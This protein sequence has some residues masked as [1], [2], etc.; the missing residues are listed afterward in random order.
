MYLTLF[1]VCSIQFQQPKPTRQIRHVFS[2][3][4]Q[5]AYTAY[6]STPDTTNTRHNVDQ[7]GATSQ[8]D[9]RS[10]AGK[11]SD[12]SAK[13][14]A[15]RQGQ[16]RR[17]L[18]SQSQSPSSV[19]S[20]KVVIDQHGWSRQD[21][22]HSSDIP[23]DGTAD[24]PSFSIH[25]FLQKDDVMQEVGRE[26]KKKAKHSGRVE[27][28]RHGQH[29]RRKYRHSR[30]HRKPEKRTSEK[31]LDKRL[32]SPDRPTGHKAHDD[33]AADVFTRTLRVHDLTKK[34]K[35]KH[36]HHAKGEDERN[37]AEDDGKDRQAADVLTQTSHVHDRTKKHKHRHHAKREDERNVADDEGKDTRNVIDDV[38]TERPDTSETREAGGGSTIADDEGKDRQ[39]VTDDV[40]MEIRQSGEPRD[41]EGSK[42][43]D[44]GGPAETEGR[45]AQRG[46]TIEGRRSGRHRVTDHTYGR[47]V[48]GD[49]AEE[50]LQHF[51]FAPALS[52]DCVCPVLCRGQRREYDDV[53]PHIPTI[54]AVELSP[55]RM[56]NHYDGD[57]SGRNVASISSKWVA[58]ANE[59]SIGP[60]GH[61]F[62]N[63][64]D[65]PNPVGWGYENRSR[66]R[67]RK[68]NGTRG[69]RAIERRDVDRW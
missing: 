27:K 14:V 60:L 26:V 54:H 28:K 58:K 41:A 43:P 25:I 18:F 42:V 46:H 66:S 11:S 39:N 63:D 15:S 44:V 47:R 12:T 55:T 2:T 7:R 17:G 59:N 45:R 53:F 51:V 36:R 49:V 23:N 65:A 31:K 8:Q 67:S 9:R 4:N 10:S 24:A 61:T 40:R 56:D 19:F 6:N 34:H 16:S 22:G 62:Q 1:A 33:H 64:D 50:P 57:F 38:K 13:T 20:P 48:T 3:T 5:Q 52:Q 30:R 35:H 21:K 37:V 29:I 68:R 32:V 69:Y